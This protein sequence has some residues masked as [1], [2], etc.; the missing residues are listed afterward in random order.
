MTFKEELN[1]LRFLGTRKR[2][3][4]RVYEKNMKIYEKLV[5]RRRK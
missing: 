5:Q 1:K 2:M 3:L 4:N